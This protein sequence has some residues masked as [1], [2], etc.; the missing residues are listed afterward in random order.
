MIDEAIAKREAIEEFL[1]QTV[2]ERTAMAD[3][4]KALGRIAG[5]E[6]PTEELSRLPG[7]PGSQA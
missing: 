2:E 3:T 7:R 1:T 6:I 4:I 5:L